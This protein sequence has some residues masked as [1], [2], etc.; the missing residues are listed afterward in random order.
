MIEDSELHSLFQVEA[1]EHIESLKK[2]FYSLKN[3]FNPSLV[4]Q[5]FR[6]AHTIKGSARMLGLSK[7]ESKAHALEGVLDTHRKTQKSLSPEDEE[8]ISHLIHDLET[9][10]KEEVQ[11][12]ETSP[13][14]ENPE[15]PIPKEEVEI[16]RPSTLRVQ[17]NLV[18]SLMNEAGDLATTK[19]R[20]YRFIEMLDSAHAL[21][22]Q[23][24]R[25]GASS[26]IEIDNRISKI[27]QEAY[28][29]ISKL[30]RLTSSLAA[31]I[32]KLGRVPLSRLFDLFPESFDE[33]AK[34]AGKEVIL[35]IRGE[36]ISVDKRIIDEMKDPLMH[37][38]RNAI[39][40]GI[41][42]SS[43]RVAIGKKP[44]GR[45]CIQAEQIS[46]QLWI[47]VTDDGGGIDLESVKKKIKEN[48]HLKPEAVEAFSPQE[49]I[50]YIFLPGLST[51]ESVTSLAGR[52]VGMDVVKQQVEKLGGSILVHSSK[53]EGS[54]ITIQLPTEAMMTPILIVQSREW[55]FGLPLDAIQKIESLNGYQIESEN[56]KQSIR[57]GEESLPLLFLNAVV[58]GKKMVEKKGS[59]VLL[60]LQIGDHKS[61]LIVDAVAEEQHVIIHPFHHLL[62]NFSWIGG[63]AIIKTGHVILLLNPFHLVTTTQILMKTI[64]LVDDSPA[65]LAYYGA[66]LE[67]KGFRLIFAKNGIEALEKLMSLEIDIVVSDL[68]MPE[69]DGMELL[70]T[71]KTAKN[72]KAKP[73]IMLTSADSAQIKQEA[74]AKGADGFVN[75]GTLAEEQLGIFLNSFT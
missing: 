17:S 39:A 72:L 33:M 26:L 71:I 2:T 55:F 43:V 58:E 37:L 19:N 74:L 60:T 35:E 47:E 1:E 11:G 28:E 23:Q 68:N 4:D 54:R 8:Q 5:L 73:F 46:D 53:G 25:F 41:E 75:K 20:F 66:I 21:I 32:Q 61:V 56:E 16:Q 31:N 38:L 50:S 59:E 36:D 6:S 15:K 44:E 3:Q 27:R 62:Q 18:N 52:G 24:K 67:K 42:P 51:A 63:A 69:M 57:M 12:K 48:Y 10:V 9:L 14:P 49:I 64:L 34:T 40:H 70:Q 30:D 29:E 13:S 7:I 22:D 45:I 65:L